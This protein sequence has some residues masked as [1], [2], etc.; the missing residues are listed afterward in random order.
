[1]NNFIFNFEE[2]YLK[3]ILV[4]GGCGFIGSNF[5][6][7][8]WNHQKNLQIVNL[9]SLT[10]A[11]NEANLDS[12]KGMDNYR[13]VKGDICDIDLVRK[14]F[15]ENDIDTVVH[16]AAE[17]HVDR[18]ILNPLQ[19]LQTNVYGTGVLLEVARNYWQTSQY[20]NHRFHHISTDEVFGSLSP[21][22][23]PFEESTP[24]AP[25]SPYSAS[26]AASDHLVR[27]YFHT[28]HLPI[29]ISNCSNN[30][31]P[32]QLPEKLIPLFISNAIN[33]LSLP[34]YG[35]GK[36]IRDWVY[37]EDHCDAIWEILTKGKRGETYAVG[38]NN[39]PTN[40]EIIM[41]ITALLDKLIPD[42]PYKP[43]AN[44]IHHIKDRPGHDRRYAMNIS[45]ICNELGWTP[46]ESLHSGLLKT[47]TWYLNNVS[48]INRVKENH[49][50]QNFLIT[51]YSNR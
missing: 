3:S 31:G 29:T 19:F 6:H 25:N 44:L 39:Q 28:Y 43:H 42:S 11:G 2:E 21:N 34:V 49:D 41:E 15:C 24:Y 10:Y 12:L 45:K 16:F 36:Q 32:Y 35:D 47:V 8:L 27:S 51:N 20:E 7:Y 38:G 26:K 1:M 48:W 40:L 13:F 33:G 18:S 4:T 14:V 22:D 37:V 5:L 23:L 46:K 50:L 9:D 30:Y 17:T